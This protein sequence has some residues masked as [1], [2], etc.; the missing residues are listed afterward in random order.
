MLGVPSPWLRKACSLNDHYG[1]VNPLNVIELLQRDPTIG[2]DN[3]SCNN[4]DWNKE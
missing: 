2:L 3:V 1:G 4:L